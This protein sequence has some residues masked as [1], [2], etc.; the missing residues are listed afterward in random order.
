MML[1]ALIFF[2][3]KSSRP[4]VFCKQGAVTNFAK[5]TG[6]HLFQSLFLNKVAGLRYFPVNFSK[7]LRTPFFTEHLW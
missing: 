3:L 7:F 2:H 6:K 5:F 1:G 4:E